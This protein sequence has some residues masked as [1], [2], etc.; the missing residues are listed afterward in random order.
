MQARMAK[1]K[2]LLVCFCN[3]KGTFG[4]TKKKHFEGKNCICDPF[5]NGM[6]KGRHYKQVF[7]TT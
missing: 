1:K 7:I 2:D 4:K 5:P 6:K 3:T